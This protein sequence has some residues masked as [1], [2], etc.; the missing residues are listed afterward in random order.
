VVLLGVL[1]AGA[2]ALAVLRAKNGGGDDLPRRKSGLWELSVQTGGAGG[3]NH[4]ASRGTSQLC[5]EENTDSLVQRPTPEQ[6][7]QCS[8]HEIRVEEGRVL[9]ESA[10]QMGD[11][12]MTSSGV[13]SGD[14]KASYTMQ[15]TTR[16]NPPLYDIAET[17]MRAEGRWLGP[18]RD[19]MKP[20]DVL[21]PNGTR[22]NLHDSP[23]GPPPGAPA[24]ASS[25]SG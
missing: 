13:I 4:G 6:L 16:Y 23:S 1:L 24:G 17:S 9:I 18:C 14:F 3:K 15:V 8:R 12:A 21:M 25:T 5:V 7:K 22:Y 10:C 20:G 19:G 2:A 11:T